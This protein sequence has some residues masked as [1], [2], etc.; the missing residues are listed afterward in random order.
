MRARACIPKPR[1]IQKCCIKIYNEKVNS[2]NT[3]THTC[4]QKMEKK[5]WEKNFPN[6][7]I[8]FAIFFINFNIDRCIC[9]HTASALGLNVNVFNATWEEGG[10]AAFFWGVLPPFVQCFRSCQRVLVSIKK[11]KH[12][13]KH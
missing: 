10:V 2:A 8:I 4:A 5:R 7:A 13:I 1:C 11:N 9:C 6:I 3:H 12:K